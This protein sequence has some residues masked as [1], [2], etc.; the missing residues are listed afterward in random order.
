M[1]DSLDTYILRDLEFAWF[2]VRLR[3]IMNLGIPHVPIIYPDKINTDRYPYALHSISHWPSMM[4]LLQRNNI[5]ENLLKVKWDWNK[6]GIRLT[7]K[8]HFETDLRALWLSDHAVHLKLCENRLHTCDDLIQTIRTLSGL[9]T[10]F[11]IEE[12]R[13][14][15]DILYQLVKTQL[16]IQKS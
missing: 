6:P 10:Y 12:I 15:S 9:L 16:A 14:I 8:M 13:K 5:F 3:K 4:I 11:E 1:R 7:Y 2:H